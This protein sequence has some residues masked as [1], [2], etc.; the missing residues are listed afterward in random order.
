MSSRSLSLFDNQCAREDKSEF[1]LIVIL[2]AAGQLLSAPTSALHSAGSDDD[3][4]DG[5]DDDDEDDDD[6]GR[7]LKRPICPAL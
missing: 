4:D 1:G 3:G 6:D 5:D 7:I 2:I